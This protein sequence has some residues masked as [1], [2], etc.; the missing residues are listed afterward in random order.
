MLSNSGTSSARNLGRLASLREWIRMKDSTFSVRFLLWSPLQ[1]KFIVG[2]FWFHTINVFSKY[3]IGER[4]RHWFW[5]WALHESLALTFWAS[6]FFF[7]PPLTC[8]VPCIADALPS[9]EQTWW[10]SSQSRSGPVETVV[11]WPADTGSRFSWTGTWLRWS[12][13]RTTWS[14]QSGHSEAP[15][16]PL[17]GRGTSSCLASRLYR[18]IYKGT[19][20][21]NMR[22]D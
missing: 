17:D 21:V 3:R 12:P 15:S 11:C 16:W 22:L 8:A 19:H 7:P 5:T 18:H 4:C 14:L 9:L 20:V 6:I 1:L 2:Y 10:L 13:Q